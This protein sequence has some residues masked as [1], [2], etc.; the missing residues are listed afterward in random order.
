MEIRSC[1]SF[2][3]TPSLSQ[4]VEA[5]KFQGHLYSISASAASCDD[6]YFGRFFK[7]PRG[8]RGFAALW[9]SFWGFPFG[10]FRLDLRGFAPVLVVVGW[11]YI[12]C[13]SS[14]FLPGFSHFDVGPA[15][16]GH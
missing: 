16:L 4:I 7:T 12:V 14:L 11:S 3:L 9:R 8:L 13:Y 5:L 6:L 2:S 1:E 15:D 10:E